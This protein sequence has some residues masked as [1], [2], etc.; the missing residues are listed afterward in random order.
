MQRT[1]ACRF[2]YVSSSRTDIEYEC[3]GDG[4]AFAAEPGDFSK[5]RTLGSVMLHIV[6]PQLRSARAHRCASIRVYFGFISLF[7]SSREAI[8]FIFIL[9]AGFFHPP[10][11]EGR[12]QSG[13][14]TY[15]QCP[16][17]TH[18]TWFISRLL[19]QLKYNTA[20]ESR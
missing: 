4:Q 9:V 19:K 13:K 1:F 15:S 12:Y 8:L 18:V 14:T 11:D 7:E 6:H 5:C 3:A 17:D 16:A 10:C 20:D 2:R